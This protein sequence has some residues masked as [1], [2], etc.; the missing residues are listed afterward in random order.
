MP[1]RQGAARKPR[2]QKQPREHPTAKKQPADIPAIA[3]KIL[4]GLAPPEKRDQDHP[5]YA[6]FIVD[7]GQVMISLH[8]WKDDPD[9]STPSSYILQRIENPD[10]PETKS[11]YFLS[12]AQLQQR[13]FTEAAKLLSPQDVPTLLE[14]L[15]AKLGY[16]L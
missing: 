2:Q 6:E 9:A 14:E 7:L 11:S 10:E 8:R 3:L 4:D 16:R 5:Q 13:V 12:A 15:A 1:P